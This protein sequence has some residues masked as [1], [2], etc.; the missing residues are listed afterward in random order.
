MRELAR[1]LMISALMLLIVGAPLTLRGTNVAQAVTADE[2]ADYL[3]PAQLPPGVPTTRPRVFIVGDS[4]LAALEWE[5]AAQSTL[6]GLNFKLDA[7]SCRT[8]SIPSC[9]GRNDPVTGER[10]IPDNGLTVVGNE[11]ANAFDELV[12]MIGYNESSATFAQSLPLMLSLA[13]TKGYRHVTWLTFHVDGTYQPPL[14]GDASYRSNNVILRAAVARQNGY[15]TLLDWNTYADDTGGLL[16]SDGA[17]L[18]VAGAYAVGDFIHSAVDVLWGA[19]ASNAPSEL[20]HV[21]R[22]PQAGG[23]VISPAPVR[24]LDTRNLNG[25]L[26][27]GEAVRVLVP[28]GTAFAAAS[29]NLTAVMASAPGFFSAYSC[30]ADVPNVSTLNFDRGETRA[31]S[32]IVALDAEGGLCLFSSVRSHAIVD[33]LGVIDPA[34]AGSIVS[35]TALRAFDSRAR[36]LRLGAGSS[37]RIALPV[38]GVEGVSVIATAVEATADGWLAVT[39]ASSDGTCAVPGTS[40][41]NFVRANAVANAVGLAVDRVQPYACLYASAPV[42]VLIDVMATIDSGAAST[43]A[44]SAD[45]TMLASAIDDRWVTSTVTRR[46]IDT[47]EKAGKRQNLAITLPVGTHAVTVTAA[48]PA[49][50]GFVTAYPADAANVCG[51]PPNA[52]IINVRPGGAA[53]NMMF[54]D[55]SRMLCLYASSQTQLIVDTL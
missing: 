12:L 33:L 43:Q 24:L 50:A 10:T 51:P 20:A 46:I 53:A 39:P 22:P 9:R 54:V 14:D 34:A 47:R 18:S 40:N 28:G 16:Q 44:G 21:Q 27:G 15:L 11:R 17:H 1:K 3:T 19:K 45:G 6:E 42:H 41:L 8:I 29:V 38:T 49:S 36:K 4:T 52:S 37:L 7:K 32:T 26:A 31:A 55:P 13:R 48:E 5:P 30:T 25:P 2:V 35:Q 23:Y